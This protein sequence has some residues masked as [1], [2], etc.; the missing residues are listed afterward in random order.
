MD[1]MK[2]KVF[3]LLALTLCSHLPAETYVTSTPP[4]EPQTEFEQLA[5]VLAKH[6]NNPRGVPALHYAILQEDEVAVDLLLK[7]GASPKTAGCSTSYDQEIMHV[8]VETGNLEIF[9]KLATLTWNDEECTKIVY[10]VLSEAIH[11][12]YKDIISFILNTYNL[13]FVDTQEN[14]PTK[15]LGA[16]SIVGNFELFEELKERYKHT[17]IN[18][19]YC[20][21]NVFYRYVRRKDRPNA[22]LLNEEKII[23]GKRKILERFT[24][25][26]LKAFFSRHSGDVF[27]SSYSELLEYVL[28]RKIVDVDSIIGEVSLIISA[29]RN[30]YSGNE[31]VKT[32][33]A[34]GLDV[35]KEQYKQVLFNVIAGNDLSFFELA[36]K[37]ELILILLD[38]GLDINIRDRNG[39]SLI[40]ACNEPNIKAFL[41]NLGAK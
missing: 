14:L 30:R 1:F 8:C 38:A 23:E 12:G 22:P 40:E 10:S 25:Y 4:L 7:Y 26:E 32:L 29:C 13:D 33:L 37:K 28:D 9:K 19:A 39:N 15:L 11:L 5:V 20:L 3:A 17:N 24:T 16:C 2:T 34:R 27:N 41:K 18:N 21:H 36:R 31:M 6:G 35:K